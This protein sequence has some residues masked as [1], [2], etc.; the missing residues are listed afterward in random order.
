MP[1]ERRATFAKRASTKISKTNSGAKTVCT[2][3]TKTKTANPKD[4]N[5]IAW[6]DIL[7]I[8]PKRL[9]LPAQP[10]STKIKTKRPVVASVIVNVVFTSTLPKQIVLHVALDLPM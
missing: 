7:S 6:L 4:A 5:P 2:A 10:V 9:V 3:N 8:W 1:N